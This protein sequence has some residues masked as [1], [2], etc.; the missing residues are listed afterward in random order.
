MKHMF[1][2]ALCYLGFHQWGR[3][4][5]GTDFGMWELRGCERGCGTLDRRKGKVLQ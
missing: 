1:G 2:A 3:W 4:V 5:S